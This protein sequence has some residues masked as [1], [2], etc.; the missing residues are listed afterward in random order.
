MAKRLLLADDSVTI[1]K[2]VGI[3]FAS[4]DIEI[5]TVDNGNDAVS[6]AREIVPDIILADVVMP[7]ASGY[8]VCEAIKSDPALAHIPVVLLTGTFE[9]FDSERAERAGAAGHVSKPFEAQTLV[10]R[11]K[12]LLESAAASAPAMAEAPAAPSPALAEAPPAPAQAFDFPEATPELSEPEGAAEMEPLEFDE[13]DAA[14]S[15]DEELPAAPAESS[16]APTAPMTPPDATVVIATPMSEEAPVDPGDVA[17]AAQLDPAAAGAFDVSSSDL[18]PPPVDLAED[19]VLA[20]LQTPPEA[21][22]V[23]VW[24]EEPA[25]EPD[26]MAEVPASQVASPEP[27]PPTW[28]DAPEAPSSDPF[29]GL[30]P[31][32]SSPS[33]A[34]LDEL[35]SLDPQE[36]VAEDSAGTT[37]PFQ[38]QPAWDMAAGQSDLD[39][40][41]SPEVEASPQE[42][43]PAGP[44]LSA[45]EPVSVEVVAAADPGPELGDAPE[46]AEPTPWAPA[47]PMA[48]SEPA[49]APMIEPPAAETEVQEAP[50]AE[51][52]TEPVAAESLSP[53]LQQ[54]LSETL[55]KIAWDAFGPVTEKIVQQALE[56]VEQVVWEVVPQL[57]ETLIREEIRRLKAGEDAE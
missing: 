34:E 26:P 52:S 46:M 19:P 30:E 48:D 1:Q 24:P 43:V 50:W 14:F 49:M 33:P 22:S 42:L 55:E 9:A 27:Q 38:P 41:A 17:Q 44:E 45:P 31:L 8:E 6:R 13:S 4:E 20:Q 57:A 53:H 39:I 36:P 23:P 12:E 40:P 10:D 25:S 37:D 56:R 32:P 3:S 7:G 21:S 11:V 47:E 51:P 18:G 5:T 28:Q 2:V 29:E 16:A 15:F 54:E 35:R